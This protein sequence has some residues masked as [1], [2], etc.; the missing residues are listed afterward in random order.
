MELHC[1]SELQSLCSP[2]R[3]PT[4]EDVF[5]VRSKF[6]SGCSVLG[7]LKIGFGCISSLSCFGVKR[8]VCY[9]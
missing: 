8:V 3:L 4:M 5:V 2:E 7:G 1:A 6:S 9:K